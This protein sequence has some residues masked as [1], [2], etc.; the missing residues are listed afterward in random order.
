MRAVD[1]EITL[2]ENSTA[3]NT[4]KVFR[5]QAVD[6]Y[7]QPDT[8]QRGV[9]GYVVRGAHPTRIVWQDG[10]VANFKGITGVKII[11]ANGSVLIDAELNTHNLVP[12]EVAAGVEFAVLRRDA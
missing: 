11:A 4:L 2:I 5:R 3:D 1:V 10:K 12:H 8:I 9:D 7:E 6:I